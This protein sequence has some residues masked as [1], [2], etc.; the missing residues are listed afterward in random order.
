[1]DDA[2]KKPTVAVV[3]AGAPH[4]TDVCRKFELELRIELKC[5]H[6]HKWIFGLKI[7]PSWITFVLADLLTIGGL[8]KEGFVLCNTVYMFLPL[9]RSGVNTMRETRLRD[10]T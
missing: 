2:F 9:R 8:R 5:A 7:D 4:R 10:E 3:G 1:M 6:N